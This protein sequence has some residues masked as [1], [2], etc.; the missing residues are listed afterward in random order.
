MVKDPICGMTVEEASRYELSHRSAGERFI[1][2]DQRARVAPC[3]RIV[4]R[5]R[6]RLD[7]ISQW[8]AHADRSQPGGIC[9][10]VANHPIWPGRVELR[11][12]DDDKAAVWFCHS[13][14]QTPGGNTFGSAFFRRW[15]ACRIVKLP[16][17]ASAFRPGSPF[18]PRQ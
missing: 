15:I 18:R 12:I 14:D 5:R 1:V 11:S 10:A 17:D 7:G 6:H 13:C 3:G 2:G 9:V 16:R 8:T 4:V